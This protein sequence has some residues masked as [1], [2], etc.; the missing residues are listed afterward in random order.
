[1]SSVE[2]DAHSPLPGQAAVT[3]LLV[4]HAG[5]WRQMA[6]L[7]VDTMLVMSVAPIVGWMA[8][9]MAVV[10][11]AAM[12]SEDGFMFALV[13]ASLA[14]WLVGV[15]YFALSDASALQA[16]LGKLALGIKVVDSAGARV[17]MKPAAVRAILQ[18]PP[19]SIGYLL[20]PFDRR[21][22]GLHDVIAGTLVVDQWAW[23]P[24]PARQ[25]PG[26][27]RIAAWVGAPMALALGVAVVL[28][29]TDAWRDANF[30]ENMIDAMT[31]FTGGNEPASGAPLPGDPLLPSV[32]GN[33]AVQIF[34]GTEAH[35]MSWG[36][37]SPT[38]YPGV[39]VVSCHGQP[40]APT[41]TGSCDAYVGD[42]ACSTVL[43]V[44]CLRQ[45]GRPAPDPSLR[46][47]W[48]EGVL[49]LAPAV[50]GSSF[51]SQGAADG[52]CRAQL[53]AGWRLAE[54][55]DGQG[56]GWQLHAVG[57]IG[58]R[59][60]FWVANNDMPANCWNSQP[61]ARTDA[62]FDPGSDDAPQRA[63]REVR[64]AGTVSAFDTACWAD[65]A[66]SITAANRVI[67][68]PSPQRGRP[69]P[70]AG[71]V[72]G[73]ALGEALIGKE[74]EAYCR[75]SRGYCSLEGKSDYYLRLRSGPKAQ[76]IGD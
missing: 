59:T 1:M 73:I 9:L 8:F 37:G 36:L 40:F 61:R 33:E 53:G 7:L 19:F 58:A 68:L 26:V 38:A 54:H 16:T 32:E 63:P 65:G 31:E 50:A 64:F 48:G 67:I 39:I 30:G 74:V 57:D 66:C 75:L 56:Q 18:S 52:Y 13:V 25:S 6:A 49:A 35:G 22:R 15:V 27:N 69:N 20:A 24:N 2:A 44:L 5:F 43:P 12:G 47:H 23:T 11:P 29:Q 76:G 42:T 70:V 10:V 28:S 62:A 4:V 46:E 45:D 55:H 17:A 21:K 41:Q 14:N 60:R 71:R 34:D 72:E 51:G 3:P